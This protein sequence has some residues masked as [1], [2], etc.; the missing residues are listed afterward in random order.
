M[1]DNDL[2]AKPADDGKL[3]AGAGIADTGEDLVRGIAQPFLDGE[4]VNP[5]ALGIDTAAA[6]V[7]VV[8]FAADP[9]G[10]LASSVVGWI[11]ENVGFLR[12]PFDELMGDPPAIEA[13]AKTWTTLAGQLTETRQTHERALAGL[14]DWSGPAAEAYRRQASVVIT[15][16]ANSAQAAES[17]ANQAKVAGVLVT[18]TRALVRDLPAEFAGPALARG[19]PAVPTAGASLAAFATGVGTEAIEIGTK[20]A[21]FLK[22]LFGALDKLSGLAK[23]ASDA[24]RRQADELAD[25][26]RH[27][28]NSRYGNQRAGELTHAAT[29]RADSLDSAADGMT[30]AATAGRNTTDRLAG[31]ADDWAANARTGADNWATR[32]ARQ[33]TFARAGGPRPLP[34][35]GASRR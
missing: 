15:G 2:I 30:A 25:L 9:F 20:I 33:R 29:A 19:I 1:S 7:D 8:G 5:A 11:I 26:A 17:T 27:M 23:R 35:V 24:M 31:R 3:F 6:A 34:P 22:K 28:P 10:S 21:G 13:A 32:G 16:L 4:E 18:T 14:A 12:E